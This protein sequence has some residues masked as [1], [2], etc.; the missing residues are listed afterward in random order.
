MNRGLLCSYAP[1]RSLDL[2]LAEEGDEVGLE[3]VEAI[4]LIDQ[5]AVDQ[6]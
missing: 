4:L 2:L 3:L 6:T 5:A 1:G